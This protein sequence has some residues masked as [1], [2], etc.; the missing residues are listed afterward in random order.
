MN[1]SSSARIASTKSVV[2]DGQESTWFWVPFVSPLPIQPPE[3]TAIC[4]W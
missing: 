2:L 3:P 1:P 4:D